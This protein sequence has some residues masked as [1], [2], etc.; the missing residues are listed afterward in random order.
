M[1]NI[2]YWS[3]WL[4]IIGIGLKKHKTSHRKS[5]TNSL[6][7]QT[8]FSCNLQEVKN[9]LPFLLIQTLLLVLVYMLL[10]S[11][12][13]LWKFYTV[14]VCCGWNS[15]WLKVKDSY[16]T[17]SSTKNITDLNKVQFINGSWIEK[18]KVR[19]EFRKDIFSERIFELKMAWVKV[20]LMSPA[21]RWSAL[22][23][24]NGPH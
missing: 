15:R 7:I 16:H 8:Q 24:T 19:K 23:K 11:A 2:N 13:S 21:C 17:L 10:H 9:T 6:H 22:M 5:D 3:S 18:K 4:L 12:S 20:S 1:Y 14:L